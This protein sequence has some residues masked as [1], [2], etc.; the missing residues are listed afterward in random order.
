M[1]NLFE[2]VH[3]HNFIL[4]NS[5]IMQPLAPRASS[6]FEFNAK[7]VKTPWRRV[8]T[9]HLHSNGHYLENQGRKFIQMK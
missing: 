5:D 1:L 3:Y 6:L 8:C 9:L 4:S 2:H 7:K